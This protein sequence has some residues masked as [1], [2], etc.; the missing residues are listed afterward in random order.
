LERGNRIKRK[1]ESEEGK[2]KKEK[3]GEKWN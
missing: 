2:R 3:K 1:G